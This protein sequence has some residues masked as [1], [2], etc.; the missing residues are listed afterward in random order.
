MSGTTAR[1]VAWSVGALSITL[2]LGMLVLKFIDRHAALPAGTS[3][4][5]N[6][7]NVLNDAVNIAVPSIGIVLA[8]RRREHTAAGMPGW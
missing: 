6:F 5:W 2:M 8:S 3:P 1:R 7:S 4:E